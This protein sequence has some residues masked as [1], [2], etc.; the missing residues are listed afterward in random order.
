[1]PIVC[2]WILYMQINVIVIYSHRT[3]GWCCLP[4]TWM[5]TVGNARQAPCSLICVWSHQRR[6]EKG[7]SK[8]QGWPSQREIGGICPTLSGSV[9]TRYFKQET[10]M[11][12]FLNM[13]SASCVSRTNR[14]KRIAGYIRPALISWVSL[15]FGLRVN[16]QNR[17][18]QTSAESLVE[19]SSRPGCRENS[20]HCILNHSP[21]AKRE[22]NMQC[23]IY[24]CQKQLVT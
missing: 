24:Q 21:H 19:H 15:T 22:H 20:T 14:H 23:Y 17:T 1:M 6:L 10:S 3:Q 18:I 12:R 16:Q 4:K 2:V 9:A 13:H 5:Q 8:G 11:R 7:H